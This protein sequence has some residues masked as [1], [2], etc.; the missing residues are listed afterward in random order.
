M[1]CMVF[2]APSLLRHLPQAIPDSSAIF[3]IKARTVFEACI[4]IYIYTER[5]RAR[6]RERARE[7]LKLPTS[8]G[9]IFEVCIMAIF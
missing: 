2:W 4:E 5:E 6:A 1:V 8:F 3:T 7:A 9:G